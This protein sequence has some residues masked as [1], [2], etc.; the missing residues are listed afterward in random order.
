MELQSWANLEL[1]FCLYL[2]WESPTKKVHFYGK[3]E[4]YSRKKA[5]FFSSAS[6]AIYIIYT[7]KIQCRC[8]VSL[9]RRRAKIFSIETPP[10]RGPKAPSSDETHLPRWK[11]YCLVTSSHGGFLVVFGVHHYDQKMC[12]GCFQM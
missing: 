11:Q 2:T 7:T 4:T 12:S 5:N 8:Q 1:L 10:P 9:R 3:M 6:R